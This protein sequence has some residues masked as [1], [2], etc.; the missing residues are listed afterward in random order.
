VRAFHLKFAICL[1]IVQ[2]MSLLKADQLPARAYT[3]AD[4][5]PMS[6]M[7]DILNDSQGFLWFASAH[8]LT[9]FDGYE[10][11][12]FGT[13]DGLPT[14]TITTL[15]QDRDGSYWLGTNKGLCHFD[16]THFK[17]Y[18]IR[19]GTYVTT[20]FQDRRGR[21]WCGSTGELLLLK[22]PSRGEARLEPVPGM[23]AAQGGVIV[24]AIAEDSVGVVWV[25]CLDALYKLK[26]G[27]APVAFTEA[28]GIPMRISSLLTDRRGRVWMGTWRGLCLLNSGTTRGPIVQRIWTRRDGLSSDIIQNLFRSSGGTLWALTEHGLSSWEEASDAPAFRI[29]HDAQGWL[30][31]RDEVAAE[32]RKGSLWIGTETHGVIRVSL[33]GLT[34]FGNPEGLL[35]DKIR[36]LFPDKNGDPLVVTRIDSPDAAL[37]R[38]YRGQILYRLSDEGLRAMNPA[39]PQ[40]LSKPGWGERQIVLQD[41]LGEWWITSEQGLFRFPAVPLEKLP[42]TRPAARYTNADGLMSSDMFRLHEDARGDIWVGVMGGGGVF[43]WR[44]GSQHFQKIGSSPVSASAFQNDNAGNVWLG[45]WSD[46]ELGRFRNGQL[47]TF[48]AGKGLSPGWV[49]DIFKDH[50]GR[51]WVTTTGGLSRIDHPADEVPKISNYADVSSF[52]SHRLFC[53]TEDRSGVLYAGTDNG[54]EAFDPSTG[55]VRHFGMKDGL[56]ADEVLS[57][58]CDRKGVLWF[59]THGGLVRLEPIGRQATQNVPLRIVGLQ[60]GGQAWPVAKLGETRTGNLR[61]SAGENVL[62]IDYTDLAFGAA[63]ELRFQYLLDG[64]RAG[65]SVPSKDRTLHFAG[66]APGSYKLSIRAVDMLGQP[67]SNP[68]CA[69][70]RVMP[71]FWQTWWFQMLWL[72]SAAA[73]G[74]VIH[75]YRISRAIAVEKLRSRIAFDLHDEV[76]SGL[77]QIAIWSEL[78]RRNGRQDGA[79]HLTRIAASS[80]SLVDTIG[81]IIWTVN[82]QRD[83]VRELVQRVRYFATEI[84]TACDIR[85]KF[86]TNGM[87]PDREANSEIR[88]DV[89]L[90]AKEAIHN[91]VRHA[92]CSQIEVRFGILPERLELEIADDGRGLRA[93]AVNGNGL[94]SMRQRARALHGTLEWLAGEERGTRVRLSM[95]LHSSAFKRVWRKLPV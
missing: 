29:H 5:L 62:E 4:G 18:P 20:L 12:T 31:G 43:R 89:F 80:R 3:S 53:I 87:A 24:S 33:N 7:N 94:A 92:E 46:H 47:E 72:G 91:A 36:D 77:T 64:S 76:G 16:G 30:T 54:L 85:L 52:A 75:R 27:E 42:E 39:Y 44:R 57:A 48:D 37:N 78:A 63:G 88:R 17:L 14:K 74:V 1:A 55:A 60:I 90:I 50:L 73:V 45:W 32:D 56:P 25:G 9:R 69:T 95:P 93:G 6:R 2:G 71:Q 79:D 21:I 10:F 81:D 13:E 22:Q 70:F 15:I 58:Y 68:V 8:G 35:S 51:I 41:H 19:A 61:L 59:G 49:T 11:R 65:W 38:R 28:D 84:C 67:V 66:L 40:S 34:T 23:P 26:D 86:E 82:P 83:S